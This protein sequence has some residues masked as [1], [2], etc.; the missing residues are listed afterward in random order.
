M[1]EHIAH[2]SLSMV[3]SIDHPSAYGLYGK[4]RN[5]CNSTRPPGS[6]AIPPLEEWNGLSGICDHGLC[7]SMEALFAGRNL[8]FSSMVS[9]EGSVGKSAAEPVRGADVATRKDTQEQHEK[10]VAHAAAQAVQ[11]F[12]STPFVAHPIDE[13]RQDET[14]A[15]EDW[16][17]VAHATLESPGAE[18]TVW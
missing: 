2:L 5:A 11:V 6:T 8:D 15:A 4:L 1:G 17:D 12:V 10:G 16:L 3:S 9:P 18:N 14:I 7:R 13:G